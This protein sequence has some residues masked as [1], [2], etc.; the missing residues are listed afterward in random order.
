MS[1]TE[2]NSEGKPVIKLTEDQRYT[3]DLK[4]WL[5]MKGLLSKD[6]V[7]EIVDFCYQLKEHKEDVD[8]KIR[9]TI[10]GPLE[11]LTD[12]PAI[13]GFLQ[14]FVGDSHMENDEGYGFRMEFS[15]MGLRYSKYGGDTW[16][17]HGGRGADYR[18]NS[19]ASHDY[20][21]SPGKAHS[22]LTQIVWEFTDV[23]HGHATHFISGTHKA[24]FNI[25]ENVKENKTHPLW[26]TYECPAGSCVMFSEATTHSGTAWKN[27]DH[28]R[29]AVF[30]S[31]NSIASRY[32]YWEPHPDQ[33]AEMTPK[34]ASLFRK[35]GYEYNEPGA[36]LPD[37]INL[38]ERGF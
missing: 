17:P 4:G 37:H 25:P 33:L 8:E 7:A 32:H 28:D 10:G 12:H 9:T 21:T 24:A 2:T 3:Y 38:P 36:K 22:G 31:Y 29:V 15:F 23:I 14:E 13:V 30:N 26:E 27:P 5:P 20:R 19:A 18:V 16:G 6:E 34:R 1:L 35:V 11:K